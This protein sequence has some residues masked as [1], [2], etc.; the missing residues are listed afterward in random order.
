M[1]HLAADRNAAQFQLNRLRETLDDADNRALLETQIREHEDRIKK[2]DADYQFAR[3]EWQTH[4]KLL[5]LDVQDAT[6]GLE[7]AK[8]QHERLQQAA[9]KGAAPTSEVEQVRTQAVTAATRLEAAQ[10]LLNL[11]LKVEEPDPK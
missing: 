5:E 4:V 9:Q 8:S 10:V 1:Q 3:D 6:N 11:Y 7:H 2:L